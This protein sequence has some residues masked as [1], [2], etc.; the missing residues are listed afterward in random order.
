MYKSLYFHPIDGYV[1]KIQYGVAFGLGSGPIHMNDLGCYGTEYKL[2]D[3]NYR[4]STDQ[5]DEDWS[6]ICKN[7]K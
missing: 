1:D 2:V 6:V 4:N 7:G 5:H 3:C